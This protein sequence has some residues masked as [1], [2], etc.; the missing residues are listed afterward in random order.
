MLFLCSFVCLSLCSLQRSVIWFFF[1]TYA[2][3]HS[4]AF[5]SAHSYAHSV[6]FSYGHSFVF[7]LFAPLL[8]LCFFLWSLICILLNSFLAREYC[9]GMLRGKVW[10]I[11]CGCRLTRTHHVLLMFWLWVGDGQG[12]LPMH[13]FGDGLGRCALK[14]PA[15][16][17]LEFF[18]FI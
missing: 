4:Y 1:Y 5:S 9:P 7:P 10:A 2:C 15:D 17:L 18:T 14:P 11:F 6:T 3:A 12:M 16:A 8:S 13:P